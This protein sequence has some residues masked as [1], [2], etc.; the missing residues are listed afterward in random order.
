MEEEEGSEEEEEEEGTAA[1]LAMSSASIPAK[2]SAT[3]LGTI[4]RCSPSGAP[5]IVCVLPAPV[6]PYAMIAAL[7]P[8][9]TAFTE[10]RAEAR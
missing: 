7:Y 2:A 6:W 4:P 5:S 8:R 3:A 10:G 9:R 1:P